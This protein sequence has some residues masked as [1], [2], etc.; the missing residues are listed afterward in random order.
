[1]FAH[2]VW[3]VHCRVM[4][5]GDTYVPEKTLEQISVEEKISRHKA[6]YDMRLT[7]GP[8]EESAAVFLR[9]LQAT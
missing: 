7:D 3:Y 5:R 6:F 2:M 1:M 8:L 9:I 4:S